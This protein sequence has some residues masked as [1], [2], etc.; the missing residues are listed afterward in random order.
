VEQSSQFGTLA[1]ARVFLQSI[2]AIR[3]F[4]DEVAPPADLFPKHCA[5]QA[6]NA[7]A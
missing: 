4:L 1:R 3:D 2:L 7:T 6:R 5:S